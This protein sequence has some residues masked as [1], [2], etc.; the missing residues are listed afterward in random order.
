MSLLEE[1]RLMM[2]AKA[3]HNIGSLTP[4]DNFLNLI[5]HIEHKDYVSGEF[6]Q[7]D[8]LPNEK[9]TDF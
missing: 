6:V 4:A 9:N 5:Y 7:D 8:W 2:S 1:R 3:I